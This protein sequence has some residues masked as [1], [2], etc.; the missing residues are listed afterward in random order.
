MRYIKVLVLCLLVLLTVAEV[1]AQQ[2]MEEMTV[3]KCDDGSILK[4]M[5]VPIFGGVKSARWADELSML[6]VKDN[7][8]VTRIF[9]LPSMRLISEV[10]PKDG[11]FGVT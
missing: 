8:D 11:V 7:N 3:A 9:Q 6:C 4:G 2:D 10:K 5:F 1:R